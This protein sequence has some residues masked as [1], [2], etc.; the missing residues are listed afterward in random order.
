MVIG[1]TNG[2]GAGIKAPGRLCVSWAHL[3]T[4]WHM[5]LKLIALIRNL[6][7]CRVLNLC[8][9]EPI[10]MLCDYGQSILTY[11]QVANWRNA[12]SRLYYREWDSHSD[13]VSN[14]IIIAG[15][16]FPCTQRMFPLIDERRMASNPDRLKYYHQKLITQTDT[17]PRNRNT[18]T[19]SAT[20]E[21]S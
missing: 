7:L 16:S 1:A 3:E 5:A 20:T 12:T 4:W 17:V 14:K 18:T 6:I 10:I 2:G 13:M 9:R 19:C 15:H 21:G 11:I 8:K